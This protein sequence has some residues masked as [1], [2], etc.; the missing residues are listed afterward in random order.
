MH[1][2]Q[3]LGYARISNARVALADRYGRRERRV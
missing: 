2:P 3:P 1:V